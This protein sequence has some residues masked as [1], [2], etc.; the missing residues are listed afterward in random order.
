M[1][2]MSSQFA[3]Y[4]ASTM[5]LALSALLVSSGTAAAQETPKAT[6]PAAKADG[7][8]A[9]KAT[10]RLPAYYKGVVNDDQR[11]QIYKIMAEYAPRLADLHAQMRQATKE[12]D[13]KI[14]ALLTPEQKQ[15]IAQLKAAKPNRRSAAAG[16]KKAQ[17]KAPATMPA[18]PATPAEAK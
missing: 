17:A 14:E 12:Q 3:R 5:V 15:K 13:D 11:Q 1:N 10:G 8:K 18:Q 4:L 9:D 16:E 6:P 2:V 7:K